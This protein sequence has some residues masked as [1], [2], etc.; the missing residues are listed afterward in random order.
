MAY[1]LLQGN[2]KNAGLLAVRMLAIADSTL[3][4]RMAAYQ[5]AMHDTVVSKDTALKESTA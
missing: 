1:R 3:R 2:A 5:A 4:D